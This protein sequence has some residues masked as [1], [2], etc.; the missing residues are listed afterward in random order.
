MISKTE[1]GWKVDFYPDGR[2]GPRVRKQGFK[3][4]L[5]AL[6]F[7]RDYGRTEKAPAERLK[8]LVK[9]W[10]DYHGHTLKDAKYRLSRTNA[11]CDRL[12]NP[13]VKDFTA[14]DW[15]EYRAQRMQEVTA[16]TCNHEQRY[17]SAVFAEMVRLGHLKHNPIGPVRQVRVKEREMSFLT[18][19]Q[20]QQL[21][22]ECRQSTNEFVWSVAMICLATGARWIEAETLTNSGFVSG[23][24]IFRDT[25]NG[26]SRAVP[27]DPK[28]QEQV[29]EHALPGPGRL[30]G[31]CRS[32]FRS[33]YQRCGFSTPQQLTHILRH[34]FASHYMMNGGDILTLQRILG[35]GNI[36][37]TMK[38][39][40]LS[41]DHLESAVRLSPV[42]ELIWPKGS[43]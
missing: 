24:V 23:K 26:K 40:H 3:T 16:G 35:H 36:T 2:E 13:R 5:D 8:D 20:C 34:T 10:Y 11:I 38:Y 31:P 9:K 19:E 32:A 27:I 18:I 42:S 7:V 4:R 15:M 17:L 22:D 33:A 39:A 41:P 25:K 30:F 1:N 12:G 29:L 28:I 43:L 6:Q 37:M 14:T 21:L